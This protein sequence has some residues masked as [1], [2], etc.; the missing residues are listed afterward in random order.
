MVVVKDRRESK[1][2]GNLHKLKERLGASAV[3][4][5]SFGCQG[6]YVHR[7]STGTFNRSRARVNASYSCPS[8]GPQVA[9]SWQYRV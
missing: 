9:I 2:R 3:R 1:A 5:T 7:L 8:S 6:L 4:V